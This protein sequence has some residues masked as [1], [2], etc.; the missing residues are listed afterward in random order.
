MTPGTLLLAPLVLL[1]SAVGVALDSLQPVQDDPLG[2]QVAEV[3]VEGLAG[4]PKAHALATFQMTDMTEAGAVFVRFRGLAGSGDSDPAAQV[5]LVDGSHLGAEVRGG[6]G[7]RLDLELPGGSPLQLNVESLRALEFPDRFPAEGAVPRAA[8]EG[9]RLYLARARGVD[10]VDGFVVGFAK[11][12]VCFESRV[13]ERTHPWGEVVAL[14]IEP[15]D[16]PE[17]TDRVKPISITL[18]GGG[19]LSGDLERLDAKGLQFQFA[20]A[21]R[22]LKPV[23]IEEVAVDDGSFVFLSSL[24]PSD[25]GPLNPF[26]PPGTVPLGLAWPPRMDRAV[27]G[28]PLRVGGR[29]WSRG[30]GVHSPSRVTWTFES[31]QWSQLRVSCGVDDAVA[32]EARGGGTVR[33]RIHLDGELVW[34][35]PVVRAGESVLVPDA[36]D[37][38]G[39]KQLILE[40]DP[41]DDWVLDRAAW[42]RPILV[43]A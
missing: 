40:V 16:T 23:E 3:V 36:I 41:V 24:V 27:D 34:E 21:S 17:P 31:G 35:S 1:G 20:G 33:F 13:G 5:Q 11:D 39:A 38:G 6:D 42:L 43:K 22:I 26:D 15:L 18:R 14:Y 19:V 9:D 30:I 25:L 37:L 2:P 12:G 8:K 4:E 28:G 7:E 32:G 10:R 29:T